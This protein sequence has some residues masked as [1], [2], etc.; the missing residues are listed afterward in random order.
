MSYLEINFEK[1]KGYKKLS[2]P[3]KEVLQR[4]YKIHNA[5]QGKD[6]KQDWIPKRV[7]EFSSHL[8]VHFINGEWLHYLP[9][10]LW[11]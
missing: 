3:A 6:C 1:V 7:K 9:N 10:G 11:Y 5:Q 2:E 8:I 4:V